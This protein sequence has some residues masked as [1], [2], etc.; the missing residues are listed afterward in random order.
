[1]ERRTFLAGGAAAAGLVT[2]PA[3]S[4]YYDNAW[5]K[6]PPEL[7][8]RRPTWRRPRTWKS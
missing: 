5:V 6:S 7:P 8:S 4:H 3:A 2:Q 1:M